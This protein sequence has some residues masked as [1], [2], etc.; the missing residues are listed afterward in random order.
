MKHVLACLAATVL[1]V[2]CQSTGPTARPA[3]FA[4]SRSCSSPASEAQVSET[5]R[6]FFAALAIDD[7]AWVRRL[8]TPDFYAFEI[9]KRL[10]GPELSKIIADAHKSGRTIQWNIGPVDAHVDCNIAFAAWENRGAAGTAAKMEPR[11][12]LESALLLRQGDRWVIQFLHSTP[13]DPRK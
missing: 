3:A 7:D 11:A 5:I 1:L 10:T 6:S 8:T 12:W 9:G 4:S 2:S 13:K